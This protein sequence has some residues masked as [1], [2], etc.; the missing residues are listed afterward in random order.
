MKVKD[1]TFSFTPHDYES[2]YVDQSDLTLQ[3]SKM[4]HFSEKISAPFDNRIKLV[5]Q[6]LFF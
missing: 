2:L 5:F 4:K 1:N 3:L 6:K